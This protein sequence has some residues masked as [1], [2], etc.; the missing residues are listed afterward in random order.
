MNRLWLMTEAQRS[1]LEAG[2]IDRM[3][4]GIFRC[5]H[6]D[7]GHPGLWEAPAEDWWTPKCPECE[8]EAVLVEIVRPPA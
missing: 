5:A 7:C 3:P 6:D 8:R 1:A 2:D 4:V